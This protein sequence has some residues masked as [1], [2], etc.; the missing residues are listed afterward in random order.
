M[1]Q[2]HPQLLVTLSPQGGLV[3]ELPGTQGTRRQLS[4]REGEFTQTCLRVLR[5]Q[6]EQRTEIGTDGAPTQVQVQHWE[7]HNIWPDSRCRFCLSE[8][9]ASPEYPKAKRRVL[10]HST[11]SGV[12]VRRIKAG[13]SAKHKVSSSKRTAEELEL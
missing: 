2:R 11:K 7:R 1:T 4:V 10:V 6:Q 12:E 5:A 13:A 9:R 8:G 3:L